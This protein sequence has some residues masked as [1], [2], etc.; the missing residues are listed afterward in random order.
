MKSIVT[1]AL[2]LCCAGLGGCTAISGYFS[3]NQEI[4]ANLLRQD[5]AMMA[6]HLELMQ[7]VTMGDYQNQVR[8]FTDTASE[9]QLHK[10]KRTKLR[11]ALVLATSGHPNTDAGRGYLELESILE[12]PGELS[13][14]ELNLARVVKNEIETLMILEA[15]NAELASMISETQ[16][17]I[18]KSGRSSRDHLQRMRE[19]LEQAQLEI[20]TLENELEDAQTKLDA[21]KNIEVSSE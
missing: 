8:L 16:W 10:N 17:E 2:L 14:L 3:K 21:I 18:D 11:Y 7:A 5:L 9:Y 12:H 1:C 4:T 19:K 13:P 15:R 20:V 6:G